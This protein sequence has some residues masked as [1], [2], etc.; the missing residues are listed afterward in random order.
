VNTF[1]ERDTIF[2]FLLSSFSLPSLFLLFL[3]SKMSACVYM[4]EDFSQGK[5]LV[6]TKKTSGKVTKKRFFTKTAK[7]DELVVREASKVFVA[8]KK[9]EKN[10]SKTSN[11]GNF[12]SGD[13]HIDS[14]TQCRVSYFDDIY[15]EDIESYLED[16][17][18]NDLLCDGYCPD[19]YCRSTLCTCYYGSDWED[20]CYC[21]FCCNGI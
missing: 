13:S 19:C 21:D 7:R 15:H 18:Y 3:T 16:L 10:V 14:E 8:V 5:S 11:L 9:A 20:F 12:T 2:T 6:S 4:I 1:T 17:Y